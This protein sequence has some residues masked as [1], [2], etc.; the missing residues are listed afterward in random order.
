MSEFYISDLTDIAD[1]QRD[2]Y[3]YGPERVK[4]DRVE[5]FWADMD[6]HPDGGKWMCGSRLAYL[7]DGSRPHFIDHSGKFQE[8]QTHGLI[9]VHFDDAVGLVRVDDSI[10]GQDWGVL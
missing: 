8:L 2:P 6:D 3:N 5:V 9:P 10:T 4:R 7:A 1:Y